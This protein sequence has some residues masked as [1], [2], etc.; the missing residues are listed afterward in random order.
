MLQAD[1]YARPYGVSPWSNV[2]TTKGLFFYGM[3]QS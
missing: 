3:L 1:H 2:T